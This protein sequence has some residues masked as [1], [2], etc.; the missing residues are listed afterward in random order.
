MDNK[1]GGILEHGSEIQGE[2]SFQGDSK[3][4]GRVIGKIFSDSEVYISETAVVTGDIKAKVIIVFGQI[5]GT[6]IAEK[7]IEI[8]KNA[9]FKGKINS[10]SLVVDE[11]VRLEAEASTHSL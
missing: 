7:R 6:L 11:G 8:R 9:K 10:P 4:A 1:W 3:I 2:I 5:E